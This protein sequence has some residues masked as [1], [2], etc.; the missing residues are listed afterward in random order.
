[1]F[2]GS[3]VLCLACLALSGCVS[4]GVECRNSET[5]AWVKVRRIGVGVSGK[6]AETLAQIKNKVCN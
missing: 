1:M 4:F 6:Q 5:R 2:A 3:L